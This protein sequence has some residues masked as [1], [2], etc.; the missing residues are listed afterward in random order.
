MKHLIVPDAHCHPDFHNKRFSWL[1]QLCV[2]E[3]PDVIICIGDWTDLPS[4]CSYD[5]GSK[6]YEGRRYWEDLL[7]TVDA[8]NKF[9]EP[10]RK[11]KKKLPRKV[12]LHGNHEHRITRAIDADAAHL[13]GIISLDDLQYEEH[14]WEVVPYNGSTPGIIEIDGVAYAHFFTSGIM[15]RPIGGMHPAY[16]LISKQ[17]QSCTQGHSHITDYS[18][19]TNAAGRDIHGLV[20]G[21]YVDYHMDWA[22]EANAMWWRGVLICD[23]VKDGVYDPTWI[24]MREIK[25]RYG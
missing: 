8:L 19:R 15:G 2:D 5:K 24:S 23:N 11:A 25:R 21:C 9:D 7:S 13:E 22:G 16:Q 6:G 12:M 18:V 10:L 20:V 17:Y 14:G 3:K 4:L 1:G